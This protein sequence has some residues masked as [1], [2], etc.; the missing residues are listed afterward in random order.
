MRF[1]LTL[2]RRPWWRHR[3]WEAISPY[4]AP[5]PLLWI[6]RATAK[7][8][9]SVL[10][11][12]LGLGTRPCHLRTA[13]LTISPSHQEGHA[14]AICNTNPSL[15]QRRRQQEVFWGV[16]P[17]RQRDAHCGP[18]ARRPRPETPAPAFRTDCAGPGGRRTQSAHGAR[19]RLN[20][21]SISIWRSSLKN[22]SHHSRS[23]SMKP[24]KSSAKPRTVSHCWVM[25]ISLSPLRAEPLCIPT[26][27]QVGLGEGPHQTRARAAAPH[28]S[29]LP[30]REERLGEGRP[31]RLHHQTLDLQALELGA[32]VGSRGMRLEA[33]VAG[34]EVDLVAALDLA[35]VRGVAAQQ[36]SGALT[37]RASWRS[38]SPSVW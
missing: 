38:A 28:P 20:C 21:S 34:A 33:G 19:T 30:D 6:V 29:P 24:A 14:P 36:R 1:R 23:S 5:P 3:Q 12:R 26:E 32:H 8:R 35:H 10:E 37:D 25:K 15:D 27:R 31:L 11:T 4:A 16:R 7:G 18:C 17:C 22:A 2:W 13:K 9:A